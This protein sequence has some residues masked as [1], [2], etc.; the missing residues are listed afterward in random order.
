MTKIHSEQITIYRGADKS[1]ARP[2]KKQAQ[3][4]ARD[5]RDFSDIETRAVIKFSLPARQGAKGNSHHLIETLAYFLPGRAK[6][7]SAP[8]YLYRCKLTLFP[9]S[10]SRPF[11]FKSSSSLLLFLKE[12][13]VNILN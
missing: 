12:K 5:A 3:K 6:D 7:L 2:G 1:V 10:S 4:H 9:T 11:D 8:L 13:S